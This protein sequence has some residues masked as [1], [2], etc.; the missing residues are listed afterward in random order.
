MNNDPA[1]RSLWQL[2]TLLLAAATS[3]AQKRDFDHAAVEAIRRQALLLNHERYAEQIPVYR[4]LAKERGLTEVAAFDSLV[5]E[6]MFPGDIFKSY[7]PRWLDSNDYASMTDWLGSIF[8]RPPRITL[9]GV[10]SIAT[11]RARLRTDD[12]YVTHS[13]GTS[14]RFSFV[15]RDKFTWTALCRN[16]RYYPHAVWEG[17]LGHDYDC[18]ILGPR[19]SGMG[20]QAA[21]TGLSRSAARTHFLFDVEMDADLLRTLQASSSNNEAHGRTQ[22]FLEVAVRGR[23]R[24]HAQAR[25]FLRR[26]RSDGRR[27]LIFG[28]PSQVN[29]ACLRILAEGTAVHLEH[30]SIV[31]TGGGWKTSEK[32]AREE[33]LGRI[34]KALGIP[35]SHVVDTYS[36]SECNCVFMSCSEGRYHVPPVIEVVALDDC[37]APIPGD[38]AFGIIGF[39]DPF[40]L[41]YPG[42]VI[43]GDEGRL[44]RG[45]C[46]CG[47]TGWSVVGEIERAAGFEAKGCAGVI[48]SVLA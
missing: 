34:E 5:N 32:I 19:G 6:F 17:G 9:G 44:V 23:D 20:I 37:L 10:S 29:E 33:L 45:R 16:G 8:F 36:T 24:A 18:L 11:W 46:A 22:H 27:V 15:P 39:L 21:A 2:L 42:F 28:P 12:I 4:H 3:W 1:S 35:E 43:T 38:D 13:S 47:L 31:V 40:A 7:E 30:D 48:A 26:A 25:Q 14:G 41:S